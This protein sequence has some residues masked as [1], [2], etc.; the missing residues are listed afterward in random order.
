M[1]ALRG[2]QRCKRCKR[3]WRY[4]GSI[5]MSIRFN[6]ALL[7]GSTTFLS[8]SSISDVAFSQV[9][10]PPV[11]VQA[12]SPIRR[13]PARPAQHRSK[14]R[15]PRQ[16]R[17]PLPRRQPHRRHR[18]LGHCRWSLTS[19]R[20]SPS[21]PMRRSGATAARPSATFCSASPA[22]P[23]RASR[24]GRRAARSSA[25]SMSTASASSRTGL[26]VAAPPISERITSCQSI[27][28]APTRSR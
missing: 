23:D 7:L 18:L 10:L 5:K 26:A 3:F 17:P 21:F 15:D 9:D 20:P 1:P 14:L 6:H 25:A 8:V 28:S 2:V 16:R 11:E 4:W 13:P 12:P 24:P 27:R 22:L 19:S